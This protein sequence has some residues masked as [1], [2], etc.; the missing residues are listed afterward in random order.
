LWERLKCGEHAG[1]I[2]V[3]ARP[4]GQV[5]FSQNKKSK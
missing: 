4:V 3:N 1:V 2:L 5:V